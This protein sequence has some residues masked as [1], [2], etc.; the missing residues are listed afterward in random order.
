MIAICAL[1]LVF[2]LVAV[3]KKFE[4]SPSDQTAG[5]LRTVFSAIWKLM[6]GL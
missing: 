4:A 3:T 2:S 5:L 6:G 1:N